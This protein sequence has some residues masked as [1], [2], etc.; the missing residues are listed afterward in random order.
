ML[1]KLVIK[2]DDLEEIKPEVVNSLKCL[3]DMKDS[4]SDQDFDDLD[5]YFTISVYDEKTKDVKTLPLII[6]GENIKVN[7]TNVQFYVQEM[8]KTIIKSYLNAFKAFK[9]GFWEALGSKTCKQF[10]NEELDVLVSGSYVYDWNDFMTASISF[11]D[12][13]LFRWFI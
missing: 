11:G 12:I 6:N 10:F 13:G 8:K 3:L 7:R 2:L 9:K 4:C 5:L 1:R